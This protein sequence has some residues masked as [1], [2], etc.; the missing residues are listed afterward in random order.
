[1]GTWDAEPLILGR[2]SGA[3][4]EEL[5]D[6]ADSP[7]GQLFFKTEAIVKRHLKKANVDAINRKIIWNDGQRLSVAESAQRIQQKHQK[8]PLEAI[9]SGII[10]WLTQ[11]FVPSG[12]TQ[13][14]FDE[15]E[16]LTNEWADEH[17]RLLEQQE[18]E[19]RTRH[20]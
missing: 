15:F 17:E 7:A 14:Q 10:D 6:W 20:S 9:D 12:Y 11:G 3:D 16:R 5:S 1:M 8:V 13:E 19:A 4:F 2:V 18:S